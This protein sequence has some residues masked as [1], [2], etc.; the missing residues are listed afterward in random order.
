VSITRDDAVPT[1]RADVLRGDGALFDD[2]S[3]TDAAV[4]SVDLPVRK[5]AE[6]VQYTLT[7]SADRAKAPAGW[8]LQGSSD[9]TTWR[10]LDRRSGESFAWDRQT[11]AFSVRQPGTYEKYRLVLDGEAI[12][13]EVELLS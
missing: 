12:L 8:T 9:G 7:S 1:P 5:G 11:R 3:A 10:T 4:T 13:A 6:A 2:T